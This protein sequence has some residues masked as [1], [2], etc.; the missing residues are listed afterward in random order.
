MFTY[1]LA[2]AV[3]NVESMIS[4][5]GAL[6]GSRVALLIPPTM[7][8]SY[9]QQQD[10]SECLVESY[11]FTAGFV[12]MVIGTTANSSHVGIFDIYNSKSWLLLEPLLDRWNHIDN[13]RD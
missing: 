4:L 7:Q 10:S 11:F 1:I 5:A 8:I 12:F 9:G 3:P 2:I 6:A 13:D